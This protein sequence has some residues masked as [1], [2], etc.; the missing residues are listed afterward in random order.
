MTDAVA[1]SASTQETPD[2]VH[3]RY[4]WLDRARGLVALLYIISAV[5]GALGGSVLEKDYPI[6][7]T[8]LD[9]GY[10]YYSGFPAMITLIDVG[11]PMFMFILGFVAYIA[12][13]SR[14]RKRSAASA[15]LYAGRR[16]GV[17][18]LLSFAN[19]LLLMPFLEGRRA[20]WSEILY[21]DVLSKL[22][23]AALAS[24]VAIYLVRTADRRVL[25]GV[26]VLVV[27]LYLCAFYLVDRYPWLDNM[28]G[29]PRFPICTMNLAAVAVIGSGF[30]QWLERN[31]DDVRVA[32]RE[33]IV[34][35]SV[36]AVIACYCVEWIQ[37][38]EHHDMTTALA[39]MAVG[40]SGLMVAASYTFHEFG[41]K[42]PFLQPLGKNLL[43]VFLVASLGLDHYVDLFPD[44]MLESYP[45]LTLVLV[46]ILPVAVLTAMTAFLEKRNIVIRL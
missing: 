9:H 18:Y 28:L 7:P 34:P 26:G 8:Y 16:V 24:Y 44:E 4:A 41:F 5:T 2:S 29:R 36:A 25:V 14:L 45:Y 32:F 22:A 35:A 10:S 30:A 13:S 39:L 42:L 6:G 27:H 31:R 40:L 1:E 46:G 20:Y 17:L 12:F 38:S 33:R 37:P 3:E 43:L 15:W 21:D 11:Q 23:L 19:G